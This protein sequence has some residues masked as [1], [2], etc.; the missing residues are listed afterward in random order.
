[1]DECNR[2]ASC[3]RACEGI[4]C[5]SWVGMV[6]LKCC[7]IVFC[8]KSGYVHILGCLSMVNYSGFGGDPRHSALRE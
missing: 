4:K 3:L 8:Y 5:S 2:I 6:A 1:M 7:G